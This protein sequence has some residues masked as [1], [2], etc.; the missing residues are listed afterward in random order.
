[1]RQRVSSISKIRKRKKVAREALNTGSVFP[2][3]VLIATGMYSPSDVSNHCS[4]GL[5]S[6]REAEFT[7]TELNSSSGAIRD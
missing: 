4:L 3:P 6:T 7:H 2:Q 5:G 1:M